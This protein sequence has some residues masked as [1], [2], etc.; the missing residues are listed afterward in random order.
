MAVAPAAFTTAGDRDGFAVRYQVCEEVPGVEVINGGS[1]GQQHLNGFSSSP[2]AIR[3]AP[4]LPVFSFI[5]ALISKIACCWFYLIVLS[6]CG[7][8]LGLR[9]SA[10]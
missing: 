9:G 1:H 2:G 8:G 5:M 6:L 4:W 10:R 3:S 7:Y